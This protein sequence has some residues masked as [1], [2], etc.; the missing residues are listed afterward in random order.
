MSRGT[1]EVE[2]QDSQTRERHWVR[3]DAASRE[4]AIQKLI[5]VGEGAIRARPVALDLEDRTSW[6]WIIFYNTMKALLFVV[7]VFGSLFALM[8]LIRQ[9]RGV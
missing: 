2:V 3:V 7:I 8:L 1:Y 5:D 9:M 4:H 6:V